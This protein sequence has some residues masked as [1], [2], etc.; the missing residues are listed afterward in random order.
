M[1][2][3]TQ[4]GSDARLRRLF[5]ISSS[6][7]AFASFASLTWFAT[8]H[9][10]V[11]PIP[12]SLHTQNPGSF[13][14][15]TGR[16]LDL[17]MPF[18]G[19]ASRVAMQAD[20][21][22]VIAGNCTETTN[23]DFCVARLNANGTFDESFD[24]PA[25]IGVGNGKFAFPVG[26]GSDFF[27]SLAI[28]PD[29]KIL[30][31]GR[32]D[33]G[34]SQYSYCIARLLP[35]GEFD[36]GFGPIGSLG[37]F[38]ISQ[39]ITA[40]DSINSILIRPNG[41]IVLV[42]G[43]GNPERE[44]CVIQL[45]ADGSVDQEFDGGSNANGRLKFPIAL[46]A[47]LPSDAAL[48]AD[49]RIVIAASC[50]GAVSTVFCLARINPDGTFDEA[51]DGASVTPGNG[52]FALLFALG[53]LATPSLAIQADGKIIIAANCNNGSNDDFCVGRL[54]VNG[55]FDL[56]F[57]GPSGNGNGQ[58]LLP[59]TAS[60]NEYLRGVA[61][62]S[63]GKIILF[64][65]CG[66]NVNADFCIARLYD[67]G[68]LDRSFDGPSGSANGIINL[69]LVS[70]NTDE[71]AA[72]A[73]Q[74]DGRIVLVGNCTQSGNAGA[75]IA[76]LNAGPYAN[77]ECRLDIDGDGAVRAT[78]DGLIV[79]RVLRGQRGTSVLNGI[80]FPPNATRTTWPSIRHFLV[81]HCQLAVH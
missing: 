30:L 26:L 45:N 56:D 29:G 5:V 6:F 41:K 27:R 53:A 63:D 59:M 78:S 37:R 24:G 13:A 36:S 51:F 50:Q 18:G 12:G 34:F 48:T 22:I 1:R 31:A 10:Q 23:T 57:D 52:R 54:N 74:R 25:S 72:M 40:T 7:A 58:F 46:N 28:Q 49:G 21:R 32:C 71:S 8:A 4:S 3:L 66:Q 76:R 67:D 44:V 11:D 60:E 73:L 39:T 70:S 68:S 19:S 16:I 47:T 38:L 64:G 62:Q 14:A 79:S 2:C 75:C 65:T 80:S 35:S 81:A 55:S 20:G 61:V 15:G 33:A 69:A 17:A 77:R 43:C 42:G 9:A